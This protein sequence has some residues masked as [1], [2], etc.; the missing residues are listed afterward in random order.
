MSM[1]RYPSYLFRDPLLLPTYLDNNRTGTP[2]I[3]TNTIDINVE[4]DHLLN[5]YITQLDNEIYQNIPEGLGD[6]GEAMWMED[7]WSELAPQIADAIRKHG[8]CMVKFYD[9]EFTDRW[10]VFSVQEFTTWI[11][12]TKEIDTDE[13]GD[14]IT[15]VIRM[16][17]RFKWADDLWSAS[18]INHRPK[19]VC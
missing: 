17:G 7:N 8:W 5:L 14:P 10:K 19:A 9:E 18:D 6:V 13:N 4:G 12:E 3:L 1:R 2:I 11:K 16:G 15:K